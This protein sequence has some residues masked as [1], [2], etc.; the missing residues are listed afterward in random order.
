MSRILVIE[1]EHRIGRFL[2]KGLTAQ[3]FEAVV[4]EDGEVG[5][6]LATTEP[7]DVV[8]LDLGLPGADGFEV[9][10]RLRADMPSLPVVLLTGRD[11][12][13]A[14][15]RA[16][17]RG[18]AAFVTKPLVFDDLRRVLEDVLERAAAPPS[19]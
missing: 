2:T 13:E 17:S 19:S 10:S 5:A 15:L 12:P 6:F 16:Y 9:L 11:D 8:L 7:F 14:R 4:A 18:A 3:G 1:D